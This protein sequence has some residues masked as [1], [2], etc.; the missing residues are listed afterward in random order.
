MAPGVCTGVAAD[1]STSPPP[2]GGRRYEERQSRG[3]PPAGAVAVEPLCV[4]LGFHA[5]DIRGSRHLPAPFGR[6]VRRND[7]VV[8]TVE[9]TTEIPHDVPLSRP[10]H[11]RHLPP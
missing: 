4:L 5:A 7:S 6:C 10:R 11:R 8:V 1:R 2:K 9:A 3:P